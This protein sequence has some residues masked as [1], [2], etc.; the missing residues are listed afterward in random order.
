MSG[1]KE[2]LQGLLQRLKE[3]QRH[4]IATAAAAMM[5]PPSEALRKIADLE[6]TIAALE[7]M[8]EE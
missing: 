7:L 8:L 3:A 6:N 1:D 2:K 4:T 5:M